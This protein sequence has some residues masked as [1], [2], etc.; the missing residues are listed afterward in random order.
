MHTTLEIYEHLKPKLGEQ[1]TRELLEW[2]ESEKTHLATKE[3]IHSLKEESHV[4][5][6]DI[7]LLKEDIRL[8]KED[9]NLLKEDIRFLKEDIH[10]LKEDI[11]NLRHW[12]IGFGTLMITLVS[13]YKFFSH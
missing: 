6:E 1:E 9:F 10:V 5:K 12:I 11:R 7:H 2:I 13:I 4:L 8:L 3:D